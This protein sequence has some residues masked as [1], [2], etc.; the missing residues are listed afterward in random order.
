MNY[1]KKLSLEAK[2]GVGILVAIVLVGL[3]TCVRAS[4]Y[5]VPAAADQYEKALTDAAQAAYGLD[6]PVARLAALIHVES[7]WNPQA[8][9]PW[10]DGLAQFTPL[11]AGWIAQIRPELGPADPW[12]PEWSMRA[13]AQYTKLLYN[14]IKPFDQE[15]AECDRW[16]MDLSAYNGGA[17]WL[18][19]DR[20]LTQFHG[21]DPDRW[22]GHTENYSRRAQWAITENRAYPVK[23]LMVWEH[24]YLRSG[25]PGS[26]V[27]SARV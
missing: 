16:A 4:D 3:S 7:H 26:P 13:A 10:A 2:I 15:V 19:R 23:V 5:L 1:W 25:W 18:M 6:A 11:T 22:F 8:Q 20:K 12:D 17:T 21:A 14:Q 27:C 24:R 9:S